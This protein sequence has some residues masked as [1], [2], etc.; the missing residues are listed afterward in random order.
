MTTLLKARSR[1]AFN[2]ILRAKIGH[3][4]NDEITVGG[5]A[6]IESLPFTAPWMSCFGAC[7]IGISDIRRRND[8]TVEFQ[9]ANEEGEPYENGTAWV[10]ASDFYGKWPD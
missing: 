1:M 8:G 9:L 2:R 3:Y 7:L 6:R 10:I 4:T 5:H